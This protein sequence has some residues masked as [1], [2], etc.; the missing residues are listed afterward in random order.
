MPMKQ[1]IPWI[2]ILIVLLAIAARLIPGPRTIDDSFITYRYARNILAGNGFLFNPGES[3]LGTTTP[4]Y[5]LIMVVLGFLFGGEQAHFPVIAWILNALLDAITCVLLYQLGKKLNHP[6]AGIALA[7]F[8]AIAPYS[9]TFSI[10]G[11]ETSLYVLLLVGM[12]SAYLN[13]C[14]PLTAFL[15]GLSILTRPDAV[16]LVAPLVLDRLILA[17]REKHPLK[18]PEW[19]ALL[20]VPALWFTYAWITFGSPIPHSVTAKMAVYQLGPAASFIR[21]MQHYATPFMDHHLFGNT[22]IMIGIVLFPFLAILGSLNAWRQNKRIWPWILY[23]WLYLAAFSIPNPLIFRWY[24]TPLLPAYLLFILIG[25]DTLFSNIVHAVKKEQTK[26]I[27]QIVTAVLL[28]AY[29]LTA[30]LSAWT[31]HPDHGADRPAPDMAFI[32]LELLYDQAAQIVLP[33]LR[34]GDVLAAGDVGVLGYETHAVLLDT[35]GLNSNQ[36]LQY[37]PIDPADYVINYAIP[38]QLV[39]QEQP[40]AVIILEVYARNTFLQNEDFQQ[41]YTL[42][43]TIPTDMYGSEGMLIYLRN[44]N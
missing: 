36:S 21:L 16:L 4:L 35:V 25:L 29:P 40:D 9:V 13:Q 41:Q 44:R 39:L 8:W 5:T 32:K 38:T 34:P 6:L 10:G 15:A 11:L 27:V 24:L 30:G 7:L 19:L 18:L 37:Y 12:V 42:L 43:E 33:H 17:L 31:L 3:V 1:K 28:V 26:R 14:Y 2:V 22:A 20:A 23:P